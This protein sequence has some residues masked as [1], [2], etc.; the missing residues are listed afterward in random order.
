MQ[1]FSWMLY[2]YQNA[3]VLTHPRRSSHIGQEVADDSLANDKCE[4][5]MARDSIHFQ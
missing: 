3:D 1:S 4:L 5:A 2:E